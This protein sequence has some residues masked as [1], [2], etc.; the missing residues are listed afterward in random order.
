MLL[1]FVLTAVYLLTL[2]AFICPHLKCVVQSCH[3]VMVVQFMRVLGE[4]V[5][6]ESCA[7]PPPKWPLN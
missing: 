3:G 6:L 4:G 5:A 1:H 7:G 2:Q